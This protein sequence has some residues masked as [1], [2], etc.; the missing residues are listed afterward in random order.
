MGEEQEIDWDTLI[1]AGQM[2]VRK[3][4][5]GGYTFDDIPSFEEH[6]ASSSTLYDELWNSFD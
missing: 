5:V 1:E 2:V 3:G 6:T 4:V